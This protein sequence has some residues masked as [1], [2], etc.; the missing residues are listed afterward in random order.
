[1]SN[2]PPELRQFT[3][4]LDAQPGPVQ[5]VYQYA[6]CLLM[7]KAGKM[8]LVETIPGESG[9]TC[10]FEMI[11]GDK[12]TFSVTKPPIDKET[13][14]ALIEQLRLILDDEGE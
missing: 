12:L 11:V 4:I 10:L 2:L 3:A 8:R 9:A 6:I 14:A 1:V 7:V 5:V 13:E